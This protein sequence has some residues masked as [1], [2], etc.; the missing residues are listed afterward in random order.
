MGKS[1][2][3]QGS[4][5]WRFSVKIA[6][7]IFAM[8]VLVLG[9][10]AGGMLWATKQTDKA[11]IERQV[12]M[13]EHDIRTSIER[14]AHELEV[15]AVWNDAVTYSNPD[16][17]NIAWL[18][19]NIGIWMHK[20]FGHDQIYILNAY[21][22]AI[23]AM[24]DG[25]QVEA[26][27][28]IGIRADVA[29]LLDDVRGDGS[30][31]PDRTQRK[32]TG[33]AIHAS[34][35][36]RI[37]ERPAVVSVMRIV[38]HADEGPVAPTGNETLLL[39]VR[40]LDGSF[41]EDLRD[42]DLIDGA[43]FSST[44]NP[45]NGETTFL[46]KDKFNKSIGY[47]IW[48]PETPGKYILSHLAWTYAAMA[49]GIISIMMALIRILWKS[50]S[51][52]QTSQAHAQHLAF[53][54]V[55]TGQPNRAR[56]MEGLGQALGWTRRSANSTESRFALLLLDLDR[57]KQVNDTLGH[58]AGDDLIREFA[59][60]LSTLVRRG[61]LVARLGGD[62]FAIIQFGISDD[63]STVALCQRILDCAAQPF[64]LLG[65]LQANVGVSIGIAIAPDV[66]HDATTLMRKAD[67]ALYRA[68][69][70]GRNRHCLFTEGMDETVKERGRLE[71][72]LRA[73][74]DREEL[75]V[76]F[77]PLMSNDGQTLTGLEALVR[78]NHPE[79]GL[80]PPS[81]F[82]PIADDCGLS[83]RIDEWV[84]AYSC[85]IIQRLPAVP[86]SVNLSPAQFYTEDVYER[87]IGTVR[88]YGI[89]PSRIELE[90]TEKVL[91]D[92]NENCHQ[93]LKKLR[94]AGFR[95]A[96]DDFGTGYS[97][98]S[99]LRRFQVDKIKIDQSFV[100][101]LGQ[102]DN[103]SSL[104]QA[105][106]NMGQALGLVVTAEGVETV[107]QLQFLAQTGCEQIQGFLFSRPVPEEELSAASRSYTNET[108]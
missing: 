52:L 35:L 88:R 104:V 69:S 105:I 59:N 48:R 80:L 92:D 21:D 89:P 33:R 31:L 2:Q 12:R 29:D 24:R 100:R 70:E 47:L 25:A 81:K 76:H 46:L 13:V 27:R 101:N 54:D 19:E 75:V 53:H 78:W 57:F 72:D 11:S 86:I 50:T 85:R 7:P 17:L 20:M 106:V 6:A 93:T 83:V 60:R 26:D 90:I 98:L 108:G 73:A 58:Q 9:L 15:V 87:L 55:L 43:R 61:D 34:A 62:E 71:A 8:T 95:I 28:F 18:D 102:S 67:I 96:L 77:Q 42:E 65:G 94:N 74:L 79:L 40:F 14:L 5:A 63:A 107:E 56:L 68:K 82:L 36:H 66:G 44:P 45:Q 91:L 37:G 103:S 30:I 38:P 97:S 16:G 32:S 39:G 64:S 10:T 4:S 49:I 22:T 99:Y 1:K 3:E 41:L 23:Y 51:E 84:L